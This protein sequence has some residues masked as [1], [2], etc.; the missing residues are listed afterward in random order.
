EMA[1][2]DLAA[3][4]RG[5]PLAQLLGGAR[6]R[7]AVGVS[8]GIQDSPE[9]LVRAVGAY[10]TEGYGRIKIKIAP[11]H[12]WADVAAV[13]AAHPQA[14]LQVDANAAYTLADAP[15][16]DAL[17]ALGL[18]LIEQPLAYDD[19]IAHATLQ[20]ELLTPLCL[21]DSITSPD[22]ARRAPRGRPRLRAGRRQHPARAGRYRHWRRA[23]SC[24]AGRGHGATRGV[25][26]T[27]A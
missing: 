8:V 4:A 3:R 7:V 20:R 2:W 10:L 15:L 23:R 9:A 14:P 26:G 13:R 6:H 25:R 22:A 18:L 21:D 24:R 1:C 27:I 17:D 12:D 19:I 16:F 5:V 11:G